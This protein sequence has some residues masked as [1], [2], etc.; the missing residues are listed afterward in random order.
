MLSKELLSEVLNLDVTYV[1]QSQHT[2]NVIE[3]YTKG[4]CNLYHIDNNYHFKYK[5]FNSIN[6]YELANKCKEWCDKSITINHHKDNEYRKGWIEVTINYDSTSVF[7]NK[8]FI[9]DTEPEA[10]FKACQWIY[11]KEESKDD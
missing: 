7:A 11:E 4:V 3:F 6:T 8:S 1:V 5:Y 2:H 10:I 9:S